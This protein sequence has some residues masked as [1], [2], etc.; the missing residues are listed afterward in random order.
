MSPFDLHVNQNVSVRLACVKRAASV[1]P[2][3]GSNSLLN[4]IYQLHLCNQ[5]ILILFNNACVI[6]AH[7][8]LLLEF[9]LSSQKNLKGRYFFLHCSIFKMLFAFRFFR[10]ALILYHI[11][12]FLSSTFSS[13]FKKLFDAHCSVSRTALILYHLSLRLS[14]GF[15]NFSFPSF[16]CPS[17]LSCDSFIIISPFLYFVN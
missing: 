14:S 12:S 8:L 6:T 3:P 16:F 10:T 1:R 13:F 17:R 15:Q 11:I 5:N 9:I 7:F 2:E 4:S